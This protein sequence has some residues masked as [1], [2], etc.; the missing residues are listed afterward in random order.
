MEPGAFQVPSFEDS[1]DSARQ[2][3]NRIYPLDS[4]GLQTAYPA[5][6][7]SYDPGYIE[8]LTNKQRGE[9]KLLWN[10]LASKRLVRLP[11]DVDKAISSGR[12]PSRDGIDDDLSEMGAK[13]S[14][15]TGN[16][17]TINNNG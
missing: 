10:V 4:L 5:V 2:A 16:L 7:G 3:M 15:V 14:A 1:F 17:K 8:V 12:R 9:A 13:F 6:T 11:H